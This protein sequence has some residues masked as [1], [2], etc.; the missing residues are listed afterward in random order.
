ML[1]LCPKVAT[2]VISSELHKGVFL[3]EH[4]ITAMKAPVVQTPKEAPLRTWLAG[5]ALPS[6][7]ELADSCHVVAEEAGKVF[8]ICTS[9]NND[10]CEPDE[11]FSSYYGQP[12]YV[13]SM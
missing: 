3:A 4:I 6:L 10:A 5:T 13:C 1:N 7:D 11:D 2:F 9:P 12:I 8:A